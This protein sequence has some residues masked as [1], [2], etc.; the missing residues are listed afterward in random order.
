HHWLVVLQK[1]AGKV[2]SALLLVVIAVGARMLLSHYGPPF[3]ISESDLFSPRLYA[4]SN[5]LP[6]LG[7]LLLHAL[8]VLWILLFLTNRMR[9]PFASR[10][11]VLRGVAAVAWA[12]VLFGCAAFFVRLTRSLVLNS[13]IPLD[14]QHLSALDRSSLA[15]LLIA[16]MLLVIL[17]IITG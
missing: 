5:L 7:D 17:L 3:R 8:T 6:S 11:L 4:S 10:P 9:F 12:G 14:R 1:R 15:G 2:W 13:V 16:S